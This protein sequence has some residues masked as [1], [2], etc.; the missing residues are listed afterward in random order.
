MEQSLL[1][2]RAQ[3]VIGPGKIVG[4][5]LY[6]EGKVQRMIVHERVESWIIIGVEDKIECC[7]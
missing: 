2:P 5:S 7:G 1:R 6:V 4:P 3:E